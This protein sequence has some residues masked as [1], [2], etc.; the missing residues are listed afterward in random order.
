LFFMAVGVGASNA[1]NTRF[2]VEKEPAQP[3]LVALVNL[4]IDAWN[5]RVALIG[6]ELV[7][8]VSKKAAIA[9]RAVLLQPEDTNFSLELLNSLFSI[10]LVR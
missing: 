1:V 3:S 8:P 2:I 4:W 5:V 7:F 9:I 6:S 10:E